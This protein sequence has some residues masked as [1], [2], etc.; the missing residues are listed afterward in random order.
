MLDI[1]HQ[2]TDMVS[3]CTGQ[4][5]LIL[6]IEIIQHNQWTQNEQQ[7]YNVLSWDA[8]CGLIQMTEAPDYV[9]Q[10]NILC[11]NVTGRQYTTVLNKPNWTSRHKAW[12]T[13]LVRS[14]Y[15]PI[16]TPNWLLPALYSYLITH[17]NNYA[18]HILFSSMNS[19]FYL[20]GWQGFWWIV[21]MKTKR[22]KGLLA[23]PRG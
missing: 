5:L 6:R 20:T 21:R 17:I 3:V 2:S 15:T 22:D 9:K 13:S 12:W 11:I 14:T 23:I 7:H 4:N 19:C 18:K 1:Y 10:M 16:V 8:S